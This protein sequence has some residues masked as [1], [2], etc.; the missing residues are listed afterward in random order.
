LAKIHGLVVLLF[1]A[2]A[3]VMT[4]PLAANLDRAVAWPGDPFINTWI[5]DW[6]WYATIHQPFSLFDA[7]TFYPA[8]KSLAYSENLYGLALLLFPLRALGISALTAYN[9]AM[10]AG[11]AFSG[12]GA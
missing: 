2:L 7:N 11:Y 3:A 4:W 6:D 5:L 12:F 10:L 1:I 9:I 8:S